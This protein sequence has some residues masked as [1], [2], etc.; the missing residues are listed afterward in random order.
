MAE[1]MNTPAEQEEELATIDLVDEEGKEH[2]FDVLD[3]LDHK[4]V[5]YLALVPY[6]ETEED[7][8]NEEL[9]LL[10]MKVGTDAE[11]EFY[12]VVDDDDEAE[13][14]YQIFRTRLLEMYDFSD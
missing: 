13:E 10:L 3:E 7:L 9:D 4:G 8:L 2:S 14:V 5:H 12:D 11:G 1:N 6:C